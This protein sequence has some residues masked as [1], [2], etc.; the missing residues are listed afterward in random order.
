MNT[1]VTVVC[2]SQGN[3]CPYGYPYKDNYVPIIPNAMLCEFVL[4]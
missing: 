4:G 1:G 2:V 3:A